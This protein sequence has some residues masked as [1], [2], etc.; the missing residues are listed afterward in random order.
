MNPSTDSRLACDGLLW[1][2]PEMHTLSGGDGP[3][4]GLVD[5]TGCV[6]DGALAWKDGVILWC[7]PSHEALE[8]VHLPPG[9]APVD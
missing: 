1:H 5:D 3:M 4:G 2:A 9:V 7:G 6:R 8:R